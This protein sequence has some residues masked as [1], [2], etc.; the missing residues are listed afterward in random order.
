MI[1]IPLSLIDLLI[2]RWNL[3]IHINTYFCNEEVNFNTAI[4]NLSRGRTIL[5]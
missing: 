1:I 2:E 4:H 5:K 3:Q